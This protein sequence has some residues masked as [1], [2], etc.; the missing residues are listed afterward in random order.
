MVNEYKTRD[1]AEAASIITQNKKLIRLERTGS[2]CWFI[3][4]D[5]EECEKVSN[6]F[7]F[8]QLLVNA[9]QYHE[10][11]TLLKNRIFSR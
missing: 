11:V 3:F 4:S 5:K 7:F 8:G 1:L 9:R 10:A 6:E 2:T